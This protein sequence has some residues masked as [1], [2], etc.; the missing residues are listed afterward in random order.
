MV[1]E[2]DFEIIVSMFE[3]QSRYY[4]PFWAN[5]LKKG[6]NLLILSAMG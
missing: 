4:V 1:K 5:T 3:L 2:L 6:M